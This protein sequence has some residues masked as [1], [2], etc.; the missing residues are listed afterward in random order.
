MHTTLWCGDV[1]EGGGTGNSVWDNL[2]HPDREFKDKV[3]L[4]WK[5]SLEA[6]LHDPESICFKKKITL[7]CGKKSS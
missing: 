4:E 5:L 1:G 6:L 2:H 3:T 7:R